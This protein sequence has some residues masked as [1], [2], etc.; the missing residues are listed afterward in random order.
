[1]SRV[2]GGNKFPQ[3]SGS[4]QKVW[5]GFLDRIDILIPLNNGSIPHLR[6]RIT[7]DTIVIGERDKVN[8][9]N[10]TDVQFTKMASEIGDAVFFQT[11]WRQ[12]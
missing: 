11:L 8:Y 9:E 10:M 1:M 3:R 2:R 12:G 6:N 5:A 7:E 4:H